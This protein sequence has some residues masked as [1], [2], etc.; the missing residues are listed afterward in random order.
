ME[1]NVLNKVDDL[2]DTIKSS[3]EYQRY[4]VASKKLSSN[5]N[6]MDKIKKI[7]KLQ[8]EIINQSSRGEDITSKDQEINLLLEE[9]NSYPIYVEYEELVSNLNY[10]YN[11]IKGSFEE[12]ID[13]IVN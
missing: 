1:E 4:L 3:E 6:I 5:T 12:L 7:K 10:K 9:L 11:Y 8:K 13:K 2:V